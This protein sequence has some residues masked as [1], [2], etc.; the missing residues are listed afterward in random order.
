MIDRGRPGETYN[1]GSGVEESIEEIA[2]ARARAHRASRESLKTIVPDRPGHDRRYLLDSSKIRARARLGAEIGWE[3]GLRDT[4]E[5][6]R[7]NRA[8]WEPLKERAPVA[9][10]LALEARSRQAAQALAPVREARALRAL[11]AQHRVR[12]PRR[13]AAQLRGR[14]PRDAAVEA[15]LLED[16]LARTRPTCTRRRRRR[17]RCRTA[18]RAARASPRRD[19]RRRS[20]SRAGRRRRAPRPARAPSRSIVRTKLWPVQPKSHDDADDPALAAPRAR[21]RASSARSTDS[22]LRLVRLDVRLA[23]RPVEDVVGREVDDRRAERRRRCACRRRSRAPRRPG[24]P[25]RRRRRSRRPRAARGRVSSESG[26]GDVELRA[27]RARPPPET[28]RASARAELAAGA[29][30]QDAA[31]PAP[32]GSAIRCSRGGATRGSSH[33]TPCSS[34]SAGSYSSVTW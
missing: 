21:R 33:G 25:R 17:G 9:K 20:A 18:A 2:D 7:A 23:L 19:G 11:A 4:V 16:R 15:R 24:R 29:G 26:C 30:D 31:C 1:V 8:W 5:L 32:R 14:D 13:R 22:G 10:R 3:Q 34:G 28:P 6:V 12:R 27:R